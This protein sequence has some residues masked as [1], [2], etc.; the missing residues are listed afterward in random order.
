MQQSRRRTELYVV[1]GAAEGAAARLA[2]ALDGARISTVLL[3]GSNASVL[4]P[5]VKLAQGRGVAAL[6]DD[7]VGLAKETGADG[8]HLRWS[9][10]IARRCADT[11][12]KLGRDAIIG[13]EA[14]TSRH[15]AMELGEAGADYVAFTAGAGQ[16]E[17]GD[18][19]DRRA[20]LVA[21]WSELFE[22]ACVAFDVNSIAKAEELSDMGAD[23]IAVRLPDDID[24][25]AV[26]P[27][28][29]AFEAA[30]VGDALVGE[31]VA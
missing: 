13:G 19:H 20:E 5:L 29:R 12:A 6:V 16:P 31:D 11:R 28:M 17:A 10:D 2:A 14:G 18:V 15:D 24:V 4:E 9:A 8:V 30:A 26:G 23:F 22:V 21:W 1:A 27:A 7:D 3:T 25:E